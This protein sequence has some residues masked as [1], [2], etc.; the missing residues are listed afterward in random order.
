M[1]LAR[2]RGSGPDGVVRRKD[3]GDVSGNAAGGAGGFRRRGTD[4]LSGVR[5]R[6]PTSWRG[7]G[8]KWCR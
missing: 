7:A 8:A 4:P 3:G 6:P 1:D 2:V 5:R